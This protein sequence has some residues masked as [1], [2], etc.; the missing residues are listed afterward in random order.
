MARKNFCEFSAQERRKIHERDN[1]TCLFCRLGYRPSFEAGGAL[2]VMHYVGR[3]QGGLG[4]AENGALGCVYHHQMLD[5]GLYHNE[6]KAI[7]RGYLKSHYPE[8]DESALIYNKW[9]EA[10]SVIT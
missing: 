8:W 4:I 9:K 6:M 2:Q 5:N 7:F 3:A 10:G 1:E